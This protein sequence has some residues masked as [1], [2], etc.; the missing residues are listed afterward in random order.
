MKWMTWTRCDPTEQ[1]VVGCLAY[2]T[3]CWRVVFVVQLAQVEM[4]IL[5]Q[6]DFFWFLRWKPKLD[7]LPQLMSQLNVCDIWKIYALQIFVHLTQKFDNQSSVPICWCYG[8]IDSSRWT[9]FFP[10]KPGCA[11]FKTRYFNHLCGDKL[12]LNNTTTFCKIKNVQFWKV[13]SI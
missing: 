10:T 9:T 12:K 1:L 2:S 13:F 6:V 7:T 4:L 5:M 3:Q 8:A 11:S